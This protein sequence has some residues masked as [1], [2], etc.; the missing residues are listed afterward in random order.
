MTAPE[1]SI[2]LT[3]TSSASPAQIYAAWTD[4]DVMARWIGNIVQADVREGGLYRTEVDDGEGGT[5][6][7]RGQYLALE[8]DKHIRQS[9]IAGDEDEDE[10][11][12][13]EDEFVD[14]TLTALPD[15]GT[16]LVFINGWNG[17]DMPEDDKE[18]LAEAWNEW[19]DLMEEALD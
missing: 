2:T 11:N 5:F 10:D 7:H 4:P 17:E 3:R 8:Q 6:I 15:G 19:L 12:P 1:H 13:Y 18:E 14:I 16:E 9:F